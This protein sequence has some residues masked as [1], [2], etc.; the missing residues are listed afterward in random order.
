MNAAALPAPLPDDYAERVYA[1]VLGKIIGVYLGRPFENWTNEA[2]ESSLGDIEY[3]VN[4]QVEEVLRERHG[5]PDLRVPLI[6]TDDDI[7]GTF[8][9]VRSLED[10]GYDLDLSPKAIGRSWLNYLIEDRTVLW[11]GGLGNSTEHTAFIRLK[12]GL[13]APTSG[14][15]ET[16]G[17]IV[18]EQIGGQIFIDG[19]AML[20]PGEPDRAADFARRA[21]SVSHDGAGVEGAQVVAA[22]EALAFVEDDVDALLD[23]ALE[24]VSGDGVIHHLINDVREWHAGDPDDWRSTFGRIQQRYGYDTYGGNCHMVP[25]HGLIVMSLLHSDGDFSKGQTIVNTAGWD[26][27]CNAGNLGCLMGI[28]MGVDGI[29]SG[30][31]W[32]G[33]VADRLYLPTADGGRAISD[34]AR[35]ADAIV[36]VA[37]RVR[38]HQPTEAKDGARFHFSYPGSVQGFEGDG[39]TVSNAVGSDGV[40]RLA[41]DASARRSTIRTGTFVESKETAQFFEKAGYALMASPTLAAGQTV[42]ATIAAPITASDGARAALTVWAYDRDDEL[43]PV[44][45]PWVEVASGGSADLEFEVPDT[46]GRPVAFVG[47]TLEAATPTTLHLDHLTWDGVPTLGL[48]RQGGGSMWHRAW[49]NGVDSFWPGRG[50]ESFRL[51][52]NSGTGLLLHGCREWGDYEVRADVTP[53]LVTSAGLAARTQGM[54]RHYSVV[55]LP[56]QGVELRA[57]V[58]DE[59]EVLAAVRADVVL[60]TTWQLGLRVEGSTITAVAE[61]PQGETFELTASDDRLASGGIALVCQEGRTATRRVD[62]AALRAVPGT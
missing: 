21:A 59:P 52:Q 35:E 62:L 18:A 42:R 16:N 14:A 1:G 54:R 20:F 24:F 27:D 10:N 31:D 40:R 46:D 2:I 51:M 57:T 50:D 32:R 4:E 55:V 28:L 6:V 13:D 19:W 45:G 26:T 48:G 12:N 44:V 36:R 49:V 7:S 5:R 34:A 47:L 15:M 61:S 53:H 30:P 9:F 3:Y 37:T 29:E 58:D 11:W 56:G 8:T 17:Q 38:G 33:P 39:A 25:N 60:G 22:L 43:D 41:I 23:G